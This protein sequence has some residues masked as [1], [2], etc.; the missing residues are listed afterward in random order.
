[1]ASFGRNNGVEDLSGLIDRTK[2]Y[3]IKNSSSS[4]YEIIKYIA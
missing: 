1:M 4:N 3:I 2:K